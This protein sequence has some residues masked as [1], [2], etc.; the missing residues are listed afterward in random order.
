MLGSKTENAHWAEK[1]VTTRS[2]ISDS[3]IA[4]NLCREVKEAQLLQKNKQ[5]LSSKQ[6]RRI[7]RY[8]IL[9]PDDTEKL[10]ESDSEGMD[11]SKIRYFCK[12]DELF[13]VLEAA[14]LNCQLKKK[15]PKHGLVV[16]LILSDYMNSRCQVDL[17][18]MQSEPDKDYRFIM[19]YQDHLTKFT[20]LRPL[21]TKTAEEVA[22]QLIDIFCL[23]GAPCILQSDNGREF[24]QGS[25]E[26]SNQDIRDMLVAWMADNNTE[27]WSE[28]LRFIQ[29]K[30]NQALHSVIKTSPY[31]AMFGSA[32]K[33]GLADSSL[34]S[35]MYSS[36]ETE[37]E[38]EQLL[39]SVKNNDQDKTDEE[40]VNEQSSEDKNIPQ[41]G[42]VTQESEKKKMTAK[43]IV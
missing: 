1:P 26:R 32:Q 19:N 31:E 15:I 34:S 30:K 23:F 9:K 17:I 13:D 39:S 14:H 25:V 7:K 18:D 29:S 37:E 21:K 24:S 41:A 35:D 4:R 43:F 42:E 40:E 28:G 12:A 33:I 10:I 6:Y 8:D 22:Y 16:Q 27:K 2:D 36:I 38:L 20:I 11:D 3:A 5:S